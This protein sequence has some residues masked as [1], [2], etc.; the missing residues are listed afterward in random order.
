L[1][2][3]PFAVN[4]SVGDTVKFMWGANNHTV[5]KSSSL[6]PCN[7]TADALFTSGTQNQGFVF[8]QVVNDTNPVFFYCATPTHCQKGMFGIINPPNA[9][10]GPTSV[11]AMVPS[12]AM[13]NS[14]VAAYSTYTQQ[15][16]ASNPGAGKWGNSIDMSSMPDWAQESVAENVMYTRTFLAAN[17]EVM[18]DDG[19]IDLS[20]SSE[21]TPLMIPM[22]L[23][24]AIANNAATPSAGNSASSS[25][26]SSA[27]PASTSSTPSDN[28]TTSSATSA[29]SSPKVLTAFALAVAGFLAL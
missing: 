7:R 27:A 4:A 12:M 14:N 10:G 5:T 9:L 23:S 19:S 8:T 13:N 20:T 17:P 26:A 3:V 25:A 2:F 28:T 22:D 29:I 24:A 16:C 15:Q 1:R 11:G 21:G 18:K 6:L